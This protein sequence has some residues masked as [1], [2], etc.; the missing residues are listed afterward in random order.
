MSKST[1]ALITIP[2]FT[3]LIGYVTNWTG[4]LMLFYPVHFRVQQQLPG[5]VRELTTQIGANIEQ[6]ADVK[7][8][9]IRRF[10]EQPELA[11]RIFLD[12]GRRELKFIQNFGFFFGFALGIPVAL[13]THFVP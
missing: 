3:G 2:F 8:M 7:L 6:L 5:I 4:V 12:M 11:N 9:V 10:E 13:L 1:L